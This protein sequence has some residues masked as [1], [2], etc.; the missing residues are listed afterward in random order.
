[1][2]QNDDLLDELLGEPPDEADP[3][4]DPRYQ[5]LTE[6][7]LTAEEDAALRALGKTSPR[8]AQAYAAYR[9]VDDALRAKLFAQAGLV[10]PLPAKPAPAPEPTASFWAVARARLSAWTMVPTFAAVAVAV[11]LFRQPPIPAYQPTTTSL[12]A[13][14][15][16]SMMGAS[17]TGSFVHAGT[18]IEVTLAPTEKF[19]GDPQDLRASVFALQGETAVRV[20]GP[21]KATTGGFR[22]EIPADKVIDA[23]DVGPAALVFFVA[24]EGDLPQDGDAARDAKE[25]R[26]LAVVRVDVTLP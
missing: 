14:A 15:A 10:D 8:H 13:S 1:M 7:R 19:D 25:K 24:E 21:T 2:K 26:S 20:E 3:A 22:F 11:L 17:D 5:S 23:L 6:G 9:P 18:V 16:P 4:R 12:F